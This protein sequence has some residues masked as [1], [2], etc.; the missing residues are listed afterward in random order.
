MKYHYYEVRQ[1]FR[2]LKREASIIVTEWVS[3]CLD[4]QWTLP[5]IDCFDSS[6]SAECQDNDL[7]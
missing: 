7:W 6:M 4:M 3:V 5:R 2:I 1:N